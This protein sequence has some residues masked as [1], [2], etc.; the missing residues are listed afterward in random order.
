MAWPWRKPF[1]ICSCSRTGIFLLGDVRHPLPDLHGQRGGLRHRAHGHVRQAVG[2]HRAL[3]DPMQSVK[4]VHLSV[5]Q[6]LHIK[7]HRMKVVCKSMAH[8]LQQDQPAEIDI[9]E[10]FYVHHQH[11][12]GPQSQKPKGLGL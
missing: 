2:R 7:F 4:Q 12:T 8:P 9:S 11:L 3:I 10:I 5:P 1:V 6:F